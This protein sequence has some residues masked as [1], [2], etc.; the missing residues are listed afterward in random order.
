MFSDPGVFAADRGI[1]QVLIPLRGLGV[2][3]LKPYSAPPRWVTVLIPLRGLGVFRQTPIVRAHRVK[4]HAV[5]I[6]L[7]GLGVFRRANR[8]PRMA[9]IDTPRLNPLAGIGCFQTY[10][11]S[12]DLFGRRRKHVLIPLRGLGVFRHNSAAELGWRLFRVLIPLRGLG[13]F[14]H[15]AALTMAESEA[16]TPVLIP[17]RGLGVF[18]PECNRQNCI[19]Q[20]FC[21]NPLAG[22]G[23]FQTLAATVG[24]TATFL[25]CF[26]PNDGAYVVISLTNRP[27]SAA[28]RPTGLRLANTPPQTACFSPVFRG[29]FG[30]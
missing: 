19:G 10:G 13:V 29:V 16:E 28:A 14:R 8:F 25:R 9:A 18:R 23:C 2:F 27:I 22:I 11:N 17:L 24:R 15:R 6:P 3:R 26:C 12:I 4:S 20:K 21:L 7:R 30:N 1:H 5:L